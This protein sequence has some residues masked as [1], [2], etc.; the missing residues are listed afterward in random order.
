MRASQAL[1]PVQS[2]GPSK[3]LG[4]PPFRP[5]RRTGSRANR[6]GRRQ[7]S[8]TRPPQ[9]AALPL[10]RV[11]APHRP[12]LSCYPPSRPADRLRDFFFMGQY[13]RSLVLDLSIVCYTPENSTVSG[14]GAS[15]AVPNRSPENAHKTY[16]GKFEPLAPALRRK[17]VLTGMSQS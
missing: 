12:R 4:K 5:G 11:D 2:I 3:S 15:K 1:R 10:R 17:P 9:R 8:T 16:Y 6:C 14:S 13:Q 7:A